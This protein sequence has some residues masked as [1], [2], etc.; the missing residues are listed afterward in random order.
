VNAGIFLELHKDRRKDRLQ[1]GGGSHAERR[2][3]TKRREKKQRD[4]SS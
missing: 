1:I 3:R 2:L 4:Q